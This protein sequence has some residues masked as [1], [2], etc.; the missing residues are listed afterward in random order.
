MLPSAVIATGYHH[1]L[2]GAYEIGLL[3]SSRIDHLSSAA[4][5]GKK[6]KK[7]KRVIVYIR[8]LA[9]LFKPLAAVDGLIGTPFTSS[10]SNNRKKNINNKRCFYKITSQTAVCIQQITMVMRLARDRR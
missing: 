10:S 3:S 6:K 9:S 8:G 4:M 5:N 1:L 2:I 7:N